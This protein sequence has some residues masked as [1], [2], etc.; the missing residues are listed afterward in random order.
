MQELEIEKRYLIPSTELETIKAKIIPGSEVK[1]NDFYIPNGDR[2]KDLRLRQKG[3]QHMVTRKT[4]VQDGGSATMLETTIPLSAEEFEALSSGVSTNVEKTRYQVDVDGWKGE[5]DIFSGRHSGLAILEIEFH[6][7]DD[8][9]EFEQTVKLT[10]PDITGLEW[11][12]SG[13]L[14]EVALSELSDKIAQLLM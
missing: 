7:Q 9:K 13:R 8:L 11:L 2:H 3:D 14:A 12:A 10:F 5:L 4:P 6:D 1:M